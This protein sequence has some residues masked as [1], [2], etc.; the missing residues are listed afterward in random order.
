VLKSLSELFFLVLKEQL[1]FASPVVLLPCYQYVDLVRQY[2]NDQELAKELK[3]C[4]STK[5]PSII[6]TKI[7][8]LNMQMS[9]E[10]CLRE[11]IVERYFFDCDLEVDLTDYR[12]NLKFGSKLH[13]E[14][15]LRRTPLLGNWLDRDE[16][17]IQQNQLSLEM[18]R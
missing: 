7:R 11:L 15:W 9:G 4:G 18:L 1:K 17:Q 6:V 12:I 14:G 3:K 2:P 13:F 8:N 16:C 5:D 10:K